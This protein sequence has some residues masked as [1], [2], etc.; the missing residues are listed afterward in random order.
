[1]LF[2]LLGILALAY[3]GFVAY[4]YFGQG[5]LVYFPE[6]GRE[7]RATPGDLG[8]AY[9]N[10]TLET[11]DGERLH[12]WFVPHDK[13]RGAVILLHGNAGNISH[14][15]DYVAMFHRLGLST[16][17]FDYRGYGRST[18]KPSETGLYRDADAAWKYLVAER[19]IA[20]GRIVLFGESLGGAVAARL[21]AQERPAALV[22]ASAFT[23]VPDLG[24]ELYPWLP[25]RWLARMR[26]DTR[27]AL[28]SV[29]CP[30][31]V[32]HSPQ[33]DIVPFRHGQAL[34]AAAAEPKEFLET[35]GGHN[36][37]FLFARPDWVDV[38][39]GFLDAH[40]AEARR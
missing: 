31:L 16:L 8:L 37:A 18:G 12:A 34:F 11:G 10:L 35:A 32:A 24:S 38:F 30:V 7:I 39:A 19:G 40:L 3:G 27:A 36:Q 9:Q 13:A 33:D 22:L 25:I 2:S 21:A 26:Y 15:L 29:T 20:A 17:I 6:P 28:R 1:M 5:R 4:V 14:R 23:S